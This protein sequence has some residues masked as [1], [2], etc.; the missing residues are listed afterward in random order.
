MAK[1]HFWSFCLAFFFFLTE[2][3]VFVA[4]IGHLPSSNYPASASG[5]TRHPIQPRSLAPQCRSTTDDQRANVTATWCGFPVPG[6]HV[7]ELP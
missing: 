4:H 5:G 1:V 7:P 2:V 3:V 6:G